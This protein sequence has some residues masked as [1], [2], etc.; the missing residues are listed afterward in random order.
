M[1]IE[2]KKNIANIKCMFLSSNIL[3]QKITLLGLAFQRITRACDAMGCVL[4]AHVLLD[5]MG[6]GE[7]MWRISMDTK[8]MNPR[9]CKHQMFNNGG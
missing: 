1:S 6:G 3:L 8:P 7:F 9:S 4:K 5:F 2:R